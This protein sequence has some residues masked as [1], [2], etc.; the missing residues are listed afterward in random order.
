MPPHV[1][2]AY[3]AP[4]PDDTY[5]AGARVFPMLVPSRLDDAAAEANRRAWAMLSAWDK[6]FLIAFSGTD[7]ITGGGDRIFHTL[8]PGAAGREHVTLTGGGTSSRKTGLARLQQRGHPMMV[9]SNGSPGCS[10]R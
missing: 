10:S 1:V 8:V 4:F 7:P 2:A 3:D 9:F 6:P 5:K